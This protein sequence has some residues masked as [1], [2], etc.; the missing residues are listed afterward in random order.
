[1]RPWLPLALLATW[2]ATLAIVQPVEAARPRTRAEFVTT[3]RQVVRRLHSKQ[4]RRVTPEGTFYDEE[5]FGMPAE[6]VRRLLGDPDSVATSSEGLPLD[7]VGFT[8][9][10][11]QELWRYGMRTP[12]GFATLGEVLVDEKRQAVGVRGAYGTPI[13]PA[14]LPEPELRALLEELADLPDLFG[15]PREEGPG[16]WLRTANRL[17]ALGRERAL[18]VIEEYQRVR[19]LS[20]HPQ[21]YS[22]DGPHALHTLMQLLCPGTPEAW[23]GKNR[24]V[25]AGFSPRPLAQVCSIWP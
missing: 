20:L 17:H 14:V 6:R 13:S 18:A 5:R 12:F 25:V 7:L 16:P 15:S 2:L 11:G 8:P 4:V 10:P 22:G 23:G 19:T 3:L 1:M 9:D 24:L 21:D